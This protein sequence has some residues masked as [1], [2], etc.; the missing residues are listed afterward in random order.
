MWQPKKTCIR[1]GPYPPEEREQFVEGDMGLMLALLV[2]VVTVTDFES[3]SSDKQHCG[4]VPLIRQ[5]DINNH[6]V[7]GGLWVVNGCYVYDVDHLKTQ[8]PPDQLERCI[9]KP[10]SAILCILCPSN[11]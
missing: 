9:R 8:L 4:V 3:W 1:W 10:C 5:A 6:N 11:L 2:C 7:D